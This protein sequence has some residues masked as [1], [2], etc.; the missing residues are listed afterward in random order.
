MAV[1]GDIILVGLAKWGLLGDR[2][3]LKMLKTS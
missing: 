1:V 3:K 2:I